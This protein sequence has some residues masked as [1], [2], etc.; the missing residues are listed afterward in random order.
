MINKVIKQTKMIYFFG[1][2][3]E[4]GVFSNFYP[5]KFQVV[6]SLVGHEESIEVEHAEKAIM[7]LKA[8]LFK[9]FETANKIK[10]ECRPNVCKQL[11]RKVIGFNQDI[12]DQYVELIANYVVKTKFSSSQ[13]LKNY[14]LST[15]DEIIAEASHNDRIWGIGI[16]VKDAKSGKPWNGQNI[17]GKAIMN[18]RSELKTE[19]ENSEC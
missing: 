10:S 19:L 11:G 1:E 3:N 6:S 2:R 7:W 18:A 9:D 14:L 4:H 5:I 13:T 15:N 12:W 8:I 17:L 16:G